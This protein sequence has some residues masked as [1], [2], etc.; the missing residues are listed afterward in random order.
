M[1]IQS[2]NNTKDK[3]SFLLKA[4]KNGGGT[5]ALKYW[6]SAC[7]YDTLTDVL[8]GPIE[9]FEWLK[10]SSVSKKSI[11]RGVKFDQKVAV[12]QY[13]EMVSAYES[14]GVKVHLLESDPELPYQVF[15]R[16]SS[17]M[18]PYGAIITNMAQSWRRGENFR[19]IETYEQLNIPIYD[20]ITAGTFEGGDFNIIEPGCALIGW[21]GS[22]GRSEEIAA[23]QLKKWFE[24]EGWEILTID[25]DPFYVHIDLMVVMLAKKL[26]AVC[27]ETTDPLVLNW[28]KSK[29]IKLIPVPFSET[30]ELGCNVVSL[31]ND[32]V[33][34]P[35]SATTLR[36][37]LNAEGFTIYDPRIDMITQGGGGLHCMCQSLRRV[38][39]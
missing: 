32:S 1:N 7:E 27:L 19:A 23:L 37:V 20:F 17:I 2:Q 39:L 35:E 14:A 8:L 10:T 29:K 18:T 3:D 34:L 21:E 4:R 22:E 15:A 26:A 5:S 6:G 28:L 33:I 36:K 12:E 25:I 31:G 16:D 30:L 13:T 9:N 24:A 11:R 38:P